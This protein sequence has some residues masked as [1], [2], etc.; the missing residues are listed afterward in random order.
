MITDTDTTC[1]ITKQ[2]VK[3]EQIKPLTEFYIIPKSKNG[4]RGDG[5]RGTCKMCW[6][7]YAKQYRLT[8]QGKTKTLEASR[9][10]WKT[11]KSK[12]CRKRHKQSR[13][14]IVQRH[15]ITLAEY[16]EMFEAQEGNCV[17]CG[18][19]EITRRLSIDH[20]HT[21]GKVRG[22]LCVRCNFLVGI[23]DKN[24]EYLPKATEYVNKHSLSRV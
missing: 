8:R 15:N 11:N 9:R 14:D 16:D 20:D 12:D 23:V 19:P 10:F 6:A 4:Y 1:S 21:T 17:I 2:C 3:C 5:W 18:L 13:K 7:F 24:P 22:L